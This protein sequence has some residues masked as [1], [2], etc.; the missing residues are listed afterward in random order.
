L[1]TPAH[2]Q[3]G[4]L[5]TLLEDVCR[6]GGWRDSVLGQHLPPLVLDLWPAALPV[7]T[8]TPEAA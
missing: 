6:W 7:P 5:I 2:V 3:V 1:V 8:A 4:I